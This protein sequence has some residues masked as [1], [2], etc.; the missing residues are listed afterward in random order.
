MESCER[1]IRQKEQSYNNIFGRQ[2]IND[3]FVSNGELEYLGQM[4]KHIVYHD[5]VNIFFPQ[6]VKKK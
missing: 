4:Q 2:I 1:L 3:T 5:R 6:E